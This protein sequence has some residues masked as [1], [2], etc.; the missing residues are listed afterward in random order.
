[1]SSLKIIISSLMLRYP[2]GGHTWHDLQ[3]LVGFQRMG[4]DVTYIESA[5]WPNSCY[6]PLHDEMTADPSFGIDYIKDLLSTQGLDDR[7]CY[8]DEAGTA[9]GMSRRQLADLCQTCDLFVDIGGVN[10]I[11]EMDECRRC[12]FID[13][14]P[15]FAQ[16]GGHGLSVPWDRYDALFTYGENVHQP[17]SSMPTGDHCWNP[18]RQ[19]IVLDLWP[20]TPPRSD[21]PWTT[22]MNWSA[23]GDRTY[24]GRVYGQ[25]DRE[26]WPFFSLPREVGRSMEIA[27]NAPPAIKQQLS[28]GGWSI[29]D[30]RS[31]SASTSTYQQYLSDSCGEFSVAKHGYVST[32]CGWFSDRS[33]AYLASGRPVVVQETG[34][35]HW[36]PSGLGVIPFNTH[37]EAIA[38]IEEVQGK[39]KMH[40]RAARDLAEDYFDSRRVLSNVI[41]RSF[42]G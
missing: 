14:D 24:K 13:A 7:W 35:S 11:P 34:F 39:Y 4:H 27:L 6:D 32:R 9:H 37:E 38:G 23:Y 3:Y 10:I 22:V 12:V 33:A 16:I 15:V 40:C 42:N 29:A 26:F 21:A 2:L 41:D 5:G 28:S 17:W 25:K 20:L 8:L 1:M 31:A 36:L 19:P 30:A 18:T